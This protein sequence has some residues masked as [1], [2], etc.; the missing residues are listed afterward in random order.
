[1]PTLIVDFHCMCLWVPDPQN[2][3][4][5]VLMPAMYGPRHAHHGKG[6]HGS[7]GQ[8]GTGHPSGAHGS[9]GGGAARVAEKHVVRMRHRSFNEP[10][11]LRP[12]E[13]WALVLDGGAPA[14]LELSSSP[15]SE[16]VLP[17]LT[18]IANKAVSGSLVSG[19]NPDGVISRV[20]FRGGAATMH[21]PDPVQ[22][23]LGGLTNRI[24]ANRVTWVIPNVKEELHWDRL[25]ATGD[26][27]L[28]SL[29]QIEAEAR[30][31][32][33]ISIHHETERTLPGGGGLLSVEDMREHFAAYYGLLG[34][35]P[36]PAP[37]D[38]KFKDWFPE[39][40]D[41]GG[42]GGVQCISATARL[43]L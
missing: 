28:A 6:K 25:D 4:A 3:L 8:D 2:G 38:A 39:D 21:H 7:A 13:G 33:R 17:D 9:A 29:G 10:Q 31:L 36:L 43:T 23:D 32:Y 11:G 26:P 24:L 12:M 41:G 15:L 35:D 40:V 18:T 27:P 37:T 19:R 22:W 16:A 1:M 20:T 42:G 5:H 14:N 30:D 34:V